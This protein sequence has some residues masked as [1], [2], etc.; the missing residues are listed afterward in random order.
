MD[1]YVRKC[2]KQQGYIMQDE[3][4][5]EWNRLYDQGNFLLRERYRNHTDRIMDEVKF[6]GRQFDEDANNKRLR[7]SMTKLFND[8]GNDSDGKPT[9]K[10]HLIED[11]SKVIVPAALENFGY[12]PVPRI[13]YSDRTM[14][15]VIENLVIESDNLAPNM[16]EFHAENTARWGR[17]GVASKGK[18]AFELKVSG[19]Q[20]D[21]RDVAYYIKK[22][23][24]FPNIEDT[25]RADFFLGGSGLSF[26]IK[27]STPDEK[28]RQ[29]LF[30]IDKVNV[31]VKNFNVKLH[32]SKHKLLF[33][34]VKPVM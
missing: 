17:K 4:T 13:E 7:K 29:N 8:L 24:G 12:I 20:M 10:P 33:A 30:K 26:T 32:Q 28:D 21:L 19:I 22:K 5:E 11:L 14:D 1:K 23:Q 25:G 15:V 27:M 9:F 6:M 16:A 18:H 2:L 34:L 31:D 3:A